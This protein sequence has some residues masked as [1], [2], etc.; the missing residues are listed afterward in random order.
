MKL[1]R[2]SIRKTRNAVALIRNNENWT[3]PSYHGY[4]DGYLAVSSSILFRLY[5]VILWFVETDDY[6][7]LIGVKRVELVAWIAI[8]SFFF[9]FLESKSSCQK[10][11]F[12]RFSYFS[13]EKNIYIIVS[14]SSIKLI[15]CTLLHSIIYIYIYI[16]IAYIVYLHIL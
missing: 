8:F 2:V 10:Q 14:F 12:L 11:P 4:L 3:E 13:K 15:K 1:S 16:Y 9:L 5:S 7:L 6:N